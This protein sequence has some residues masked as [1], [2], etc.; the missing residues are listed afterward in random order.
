MKLVIIESP[1]AGDVERNLRY[2]RE[3]LRDSVARGESP[4][5]S[6]RMLTDALDDTIPTEREA[7]IKAGLAW[8]GVAD[9]IVF[10]VDLGWSG[11]MKAAR[12]HYEKNGA[13]WSTRR[14]HGDGKKIVDPGTR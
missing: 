1:Y 7:G 10:Y 3:C 5:A 8:A 11:G 14:L 9:E 4:Y 6:H 2:L 13:I 12:A